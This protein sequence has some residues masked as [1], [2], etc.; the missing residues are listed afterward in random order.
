VQDI[1]PVTEERWGD[2]ARFFQAHGNPNYCWCMTWRVASTEFHALSSEERKA[3]LHASLASGQPIGLLAYL[4]GE[5]AGW[6]SVAPRSTYPRLERSR[7][8]PRLDELDTWSVVCFFLAKEAR[9][10]GLSVE[11]LRAA[12]EYAAEHGAQV[13]EG[14]PVEPVPDENGALRVPASYRFMGYRRSFEKAGFKDVTPP[15]ATRTIMRFE[16]PPAGRGK[17][18]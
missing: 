3:A 13:V 15:G 18:G 17:R 14:Y 9:G 12:I 11:L 16:I 1:Y 10:R 5:P 8:M 7:T 6:C 2:L 4:D